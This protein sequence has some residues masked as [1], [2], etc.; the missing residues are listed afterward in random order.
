MLYKYVRVMLETSQQTDTLVQT[1][2]HTHL[3]AAMH[4]AVSHLQYKHMDGHRIIAS[5][6]CEP[7]KKL[8]YFP[9][10]PVFFFFENAENHHVT[11][12]TLPGLM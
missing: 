3:P 4:H 12:I 10:R 5:R 7:N 1:T 6:P 8:L 2:K 11:H 9:S